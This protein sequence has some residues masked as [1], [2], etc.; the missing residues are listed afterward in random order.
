MKCKHCGKPIILTHS[1]YAHPTE[2][3]FDSIGQIYYAEYCS[4]I[5]PGYEKATPMTKSDNFQHIYKILNG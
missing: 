1:G 5:G 4:I 3:Q 2:Y